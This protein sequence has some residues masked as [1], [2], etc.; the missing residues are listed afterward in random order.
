MSG[1]KRDVDEEEDEEEEELDEETQY[2]MDC[3]KHQ[4][5]IDKRRK[6]RKQIR[7]LDEKYVTNSA[8]LADLNNEQLQKLHKQQDQIFTTVNH[9]R[10]QLLDAQTLNKAA[11]ILRTAAINADDASKRY[12]IHTVLH[13]VSI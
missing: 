7:E 9:V 1:H 8:Q 10:E 6:V 2:Q 12:P 13:T 11:D 3:E 5:T 4:E